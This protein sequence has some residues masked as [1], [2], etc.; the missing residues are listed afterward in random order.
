MFEIIKSFL[1]ILFYKFKRITG[2]TLLK[3]KIIVFN[4]HLEPF[5]TFLNLL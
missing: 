1:S 4:R 5:R 2:K 3:I